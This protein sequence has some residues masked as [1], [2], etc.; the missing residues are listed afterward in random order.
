MRVSTTRLKRRLF[1]RIIWLAEADAHRV[2][3]VLG[4]ELRIGH[5]GIEDVVLGPGGE[6]GVPEYAFQLIDSVVTQGSDSSSGTGVHQNKR[7]P[8]LAQSSRLR[9]PDHERR[10]LATDHGA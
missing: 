10:R 4:Y 7:T 1:R 3:S 5:K 6:S 2:I 9:Y 8:F